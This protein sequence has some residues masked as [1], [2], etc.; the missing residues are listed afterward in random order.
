MQQTS[1]EEMKMQE[2]KNALR[3]LEG[4]MVRRLAAGPGRH[5]P[6][7]AS[8]PQCLLSQSARGLVLCASERKKKNFLHLSRRPTLS[9]DTVGFTCL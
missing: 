8:C 1:L 7:P 3:K 9:R 2:K 6:A 4:S 5:F